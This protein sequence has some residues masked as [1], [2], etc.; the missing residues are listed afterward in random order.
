MVSSTRLCGCFGKH[1]CV[2]D[3]INI[4][5]LFILLIPRYVLRNVACLVQHWRCIP[6]SPFHTT[7]T[8][9]QWWQVKNLQ[10]TSNIQFH[11]SGF[12]WAPYLYLMG[13]GHIYT[14]L[15]TTLRHAAV[16]HTSDT[17]SLPFWNSYGDSGERPT[18]VPSSDKGWHPS[19][20]H[21][22]HPWTSHLQSMPFDTAPN[23][24]AA[25][26]FRAIDRFCTS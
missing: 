8:I 3:A 24:P 20:K 21:S 13:G 16:L 5:G 1:R 2:L 17:P 9:M 15:L 7:D 11:S 12:F 25:S 10:L 14:R 26:S 22:L 4:E 18:I 6:R 23:H 19:L